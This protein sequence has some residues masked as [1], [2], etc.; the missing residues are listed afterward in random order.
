MNLGKRCQLY[1]FIHVLAHLILLP[2]LTHRM[3]LARWIERNTKNASCSLKPHSFC[4]DEHQW[5]M[6]YIIIGKLFSMN[7]GSVP[8]VSNIYFT[9]ALNSN[10]YHINLRPGFFK[11]FDDKDPEIWWSPSFLK[12][13]CNNICNKKPIHTVWK[14]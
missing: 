5:G 9:S 3:T 2:K 7:R 10:R 13:K 8:Q 6:H 14:K 12:Y 4:G 11:L 1:C